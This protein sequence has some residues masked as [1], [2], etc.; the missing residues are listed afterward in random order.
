MSTAWRIRRLGLPVLQCVRNFR[1]DRAVYE[2]WHSSLWN[3]CHHAASDS[4]RMTT[5][6]FD[7]SRTRFHFTRR[8]KRRV[9]RRN[10]TFIRREGTDSAFES[11][12]VP[13]T[14]MATGRT[15]YDCSTFIPFFGSARMVGVS[16]FD[17]FCN[18][19]RNPSR[20]A[21][22][23]FVWRSLISPRVLDLAVFRFRTRFPLIA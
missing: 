7:R 16:F 15:S 1:R 5:D 17:L 18:A 9:S 4:M 19:E 13:L 22:A 12:H 14:P 11:K 10:S 8:G 3:R 2:E 20:V 23:T 6:W 21:V